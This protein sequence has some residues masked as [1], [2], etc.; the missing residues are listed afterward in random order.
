MEINSRGLQIIKVCE[1]L[2]LDAY[3]CSAGIWTIG[4]GSID[5]AGV[6]VTEGLRI[7]E[8]KA[9]KLLLDDLAWTYK[10]IARY[11]RVEL[12]SNQF[13]ALCSFIFN[14]G[15]GNFK[16]STLRQKLNRG[17]FIGASNEFWKWRR[18]NGIILRGLV[19]RRELEELLFLLPTSHKH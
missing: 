10:I 8:S 11:V 7:D 9:D 6:P 17:D 18:A 12:N 13:S 15:S 16:A 1:G 2:R 19:K 14:I 5:D 4:Y 3:K